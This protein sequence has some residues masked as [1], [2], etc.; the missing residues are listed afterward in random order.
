MGVIWNNSTGTVPPYYWPHG[1]SQDSS[2]AQ[3]YIEL[4]GTQGYQV[5]GN[6]DLENG[7]EKFALY[8]LD[9]KFTHVARQLP[10]GRWTSK[11]GILK[12]IMHDLSDLEANHHKHTYGKASIFLKRELEHIMPRLSRKST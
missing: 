3:T 11:L 5:T 6:P 9:G 7:F 8:V 10:N 2:L 1:I 4:F 12:D